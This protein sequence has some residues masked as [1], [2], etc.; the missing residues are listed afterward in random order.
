MPAVEDVDAE[1]D[2]AVLPST[3]DPVVAGSGPPPATTTTST[4]SADTAAAAHAAGRPKVCGPPWRLVRRRRRP[5]P[6]VTARAD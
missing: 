1:A 6:G 5:L 2:A 4:T 3:P